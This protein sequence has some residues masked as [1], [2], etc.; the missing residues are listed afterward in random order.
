MWQGQNLRRDAGVE[1]RRQGRAALGRWLLN[2]RRGVAAK[3]SSRGGPPFAAG[4]S[5]ER[6]SVEQACRDFAP[7]R[8]RTGIRWNQDGNGLRRAWI[9]GGWPRNREAATHHGG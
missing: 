6:R 2:V 7:M 3:N 5:G 1:A 8:C 9:P 4:R